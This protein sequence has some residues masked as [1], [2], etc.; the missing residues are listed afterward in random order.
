LSQNAWYGIERDNTIASKDFT[1]IAGT[2]FMSLHASLPIQNSIKGVLMAADKSV[3]YYLNA[4]DWTKKADG[5]ASNRSGVDGNVMAYRSK[6]CYWKYETVGNIERVKVS[7]FPLTGFTKSS[8]C[9]YSSYEGKLVGTKLS[10]V[11]GVLPTTSRTE[12]QFRAD[13]R[14]NGAGYQQQWY[15][16]YKEQLWLFMIEFATSDFQKPVNNLLTAEGYKQG[17]LGD[18]VTTANSTEWSSLNGYNPFIICGSSDSLGNGSGEVATVIPNFGGAGTNLTFT[19]PRYRGI[20][21]LFGHVW[22]WVD[23]G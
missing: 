21:N 3:N 20:E 22:K 5:T 7:E 19:V 6:D 4:D 16:P 14:A 13:A 11:A 2:G 17:G 1:R 10:S 12:T 23:G 9:F 18:G 15:D 8:K